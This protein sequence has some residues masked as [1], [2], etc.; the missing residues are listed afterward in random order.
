MTGYV[1]YGKLL[2]LIPLIL[3]TA[4][5]CVGTAEWNQEAS[6]FQTE[7]EMIQTERQSRNAAKDEDDVRIDDTENLMIEE[8][9]VKEN[10][11]KEN[12]TEDTKTTGNIRDAGA[13]VECSGAVQQTSAERNGTIHPSS[14]EN[15]DTIRQSEIQQTTENS[16]RIYHLSKQDYEILL[17]IVEAEAGGEDENG[18]LLVA[19]VVLNRVNDPYFPDTV[20][21]VVYQKEQGIYQFSPVKDGRLEQVEISESTQRA[22]E[23]AVCGEDISRG[24]LYFIARSAVSEEK[25]TWFDTQLTWLFAYGGHEFFE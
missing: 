13:A 6:R 2:M 7:E 23:R 12:S 5:L 21:E 17:K 3:M 8:N 19:N 15:G 20:T 24:A 9:V 18:K 25:L 11:I 4:R 16:S 22:V 10:I 14:G 1:W